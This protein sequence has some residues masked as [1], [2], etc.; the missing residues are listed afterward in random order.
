MYVFLLKI[1]KSYLFICNTPL[2]NLVLLGLFSLFITGCNVEQF[3]QKDQYIIRKND[4]KLKNN[5]NR[6]TRNTL[7]VELS[8]FYKQRDL[9]EPLIGKSKSGAWFWLKAQVDSSYND[10]KFKTFARKPSFLDENAT[11]STVK[12]MKQYLKNSGYLYP[13][14]YSD[15]NFHNKERGLADITYMVDAGIL[16]VVDTVNFVCSDT[17]IQYL[18]NDI[19]DKTTFS[20]Y[21]P[22]DARLYAREKERITTEFNNLGYARFTDNYIEPLESDTTNIKFDGKGNR[23]VNIT[24]TIGKPNDTLAFK[25]FL[26]GQ[27]TVYPKYDATRG[28]TIANDSIIDGKIFL[29]YDKGDIGLRAA[30]LSKAVRL[31]P[32]EVYKKE[33]ADKTLRRLTNLG[34]YRFVNIKPLV[35][36]CET[37]AINYKV[38]LTPSKKMTFEAGAEV[39]YS[40]ISSISSGAL[41]RIGAAVDLGF[42]HRNLFHG[43][44]HFNSKLSGGLD[45]GL[46]K[47]TAQ[48][49]FSSDIRFENT[50]SIPKF[51]NPTHVWRMYNR[52]GIIKSGF[53]KDLLDNASSNINVSYY[54]SDRLALKLYRLQQFNLNFRY[55]LNRQNGAER[56]NINQSGVELQLTQ[57]NSTFEKRINE[58]FRRSL[59]K[60]ILTGFAFRSLTYERTVASNLFAEKWQFLGSF[61]QSG[62]EI[63]LAEQVFNK[64][65]PFEI[66]KVTFSKFVRTEFDMRYTRQYTQKR[67]FAARLAVGLAVPFGG[68]AVPYARQFYVG[69]PSSVRGWLAR[70]IG[71]GTYRDTTNTSLPFQ[72]GDIKIEFNSEYRFPLFW[73][74]ESAIFLDAGNIWNLRPDEKVAGTEFGKYWFD[75]MAISSGVGLRI[76]VKYALV[77]LDFGFK[78]RN[79]YKDTIRNSNWISAK[80][81]SWDNNVN[82]NIAI[83]FPF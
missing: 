52:L 77:R 64:G 54:F 68:A 78:L 9:P 73:I 21:T 48:N 26:T 13:T 37:N 58:R 22:L 31:Q 65:I 5:L 71:P 60:Q 62:S 11:L 3:L 74:I 59:Q 81:Y 56:Y 25:K 80:K 28:E 36:D 50:L 57:L 8:T 39:N 69:G 17:A 51:V 19:A 75:Q 47:D 29:T 44:E 67:A 66:A 49:G 32:D 82:F 35:D 61:E 10:W 41:G 30:P 83:G 72:A 42:S 43:A 79:P 53:Y 24:L 38:Y 40:N 7:K 2:S 20:R 33:N 4:I 23:L 14:I 76:D 34:I 55:L 46:G 6:R 1:K 18:L 27:V 63:W 12:N 15:K 45:Y 16:Y 70:G